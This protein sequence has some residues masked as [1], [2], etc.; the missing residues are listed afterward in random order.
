M[1]ER[2]RQGLG[3]KKDLKKKKGAA[4]WELISWPGVRSEFN[5]RLS[6]QLGRTISHDG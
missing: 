2:Y 3:R 1:L 5:K 4:D 6:C